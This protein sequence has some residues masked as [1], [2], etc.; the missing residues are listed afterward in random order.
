[1]PT[2]SAQTQEGQTLDS[3][4]SGARSVRT[5]RRTVWFPTLSSVRA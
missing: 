2:R 4:S 1:L 5:S 3:P